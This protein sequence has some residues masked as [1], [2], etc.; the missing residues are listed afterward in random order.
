MNICEDF[1]ITNLQVIPFIVSVIDIQ[2][3]NN[4]TELF[5][6][7]LMIFSLW[8]SKNAI[9]TTLLLLFIKTNNQYLYKILLKHKMPNSW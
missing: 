3:K 5:H 8:V 1:S 9:S 2:T 4:D 7:L 6:Q